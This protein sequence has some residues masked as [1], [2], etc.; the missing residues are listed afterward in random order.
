M[1]FQE[2]AGLATLPGLPD[3]MRED[4]VSATYRRLTGV[5][6]G[7]LRWFYVYSGVMW[8]CVFMRTGARRV[9]FGEIAMPTD[10]ESLFYHGALLKRLIGEGA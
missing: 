10:V 1:V 7:D 3:V 8:A 2:L 9:H 5:E 4:D 6:L